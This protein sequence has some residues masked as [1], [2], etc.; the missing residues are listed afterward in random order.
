M[1]FFKE[2]TLLE[3]SGQMNRNKGRLSVIPQ[4]G[5]QNAGMH[6]EDRPSVYAV[7]FDERQRV[8]VVAVRGKY[9]LP[10]GGIEPGEQPRNALIREV[11]EETGWSVT[12][13]R[14]I[15]SAREYV[16]AKREQVAVNKIGEFYMATVVD[17]EGRRSE[18]SHVAKW[19][20]IAE[21]EKKAGHASHV[22]AVTRALETRNID[23][24]LRT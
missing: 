22:W 4:F 10:G 18:K 17:R 23:L 1:M 16:Y 11:R 7:I 9:F 5:T 20:T 15:G 12:V 14:R 21:F 6:Y 3:V 13:G 2:K 24:D 8:A 19:I